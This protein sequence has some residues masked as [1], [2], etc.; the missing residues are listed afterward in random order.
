VAEAIPWPKMGWSGHPIFG[1]GL[2]LATPRFPPP[3]FLNF[4][5]FFKKKKKLK[6]PKLR[7]F[8][9]NGVILE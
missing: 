4:L 8:G 7:R 3:F 5:L 1:Q 9:K 2:A 6:W